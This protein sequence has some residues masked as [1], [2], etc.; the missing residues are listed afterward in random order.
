MMVCTLYDTDEEGWEQAKYNMAKTTVKIEDGMVQ[1][2]EGIPADVTI[3]VCK[4]DVSAVDEKMLTKDE[5]GKSC[6]I[7][8]WHAPE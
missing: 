7:R 1:T 8:E 6:G 3:E 4:Y 5:N 2:V